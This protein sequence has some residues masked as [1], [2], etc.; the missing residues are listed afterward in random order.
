MPLVNGPVDWDRIDLVVF[1]V[2]G[3]LYRQAPVRAHMMVKIGVEVLRNRSL[4]LPRLLR[5]YRQCREELALRPH[6]DF[7]RRQYASTAE[8]MG[9]APDEVE[10]LVEEWMQLR[11]LPLLKASRV[12]GID[13]LFRA[14]R[15]TGK[16]I[17]IFS[18]YPAD[19]KLAAMGLE[20]DWIAC[21]G[22][23]EV[24]RLKPEPAGLIKLL[25]WSGV[26]PERAILVGDRVDRDW[27][28]GSR[29]G[30]RTII[31]SRRSCRH[32]DSFARYTD[33]PFAELL[34]SRT[35]LGKASAYA[36]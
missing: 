12:E 25:Q 23:A 17:G 4:T 33:P 13:L 26:A 18:D 35:Q 5:R 22:H 24:G 1:D 29:A 19:A 11:P 20:A 2:D 36:S 15:S 21:A 3:T 27:E 16:M 8:H 10:A 30:V 32:V 7:R 6:E 31:R 14:L 9:C 34:K 28:A